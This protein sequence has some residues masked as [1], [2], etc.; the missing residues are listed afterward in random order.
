MIITCH[1]LNHEAMILLY[2]GHC[3]MAV[4][5]L[6]ND[7]IS[8]REIASYNESR[9]HFN[10]RYSVFINKLEWRAVENYLKII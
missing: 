1:N 9:L 5:K 2:F 6:F 3:S 4:S 8:S 7:D 10:G